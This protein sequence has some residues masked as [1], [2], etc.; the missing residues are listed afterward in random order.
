MRNDDDSEEEEALK[1]DAS[2]KTPQEMI[3]DHLNK[4]SDDPSYSR[5]YRSH[6]GN[7]SSSRSDDLSTTT[8][9]TPSEVII[10]PASTTI[11]T[12]HWFV[13]YWRPAAAW[14]YLIIVLFDFMLAPMFMAWFAY[15]TKT[16]LVPWDPLTTHG[17]SI[18]HLAFG[19]ILGIYVYGRTREKLAGVE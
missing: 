16:T 19:A 3:K 6:S 10:K 12:E 5:G 18:F 7:Y 17:G 13:S 2:T 9:T 15:A 14:V 8:V 4:R 11:Q 1:K